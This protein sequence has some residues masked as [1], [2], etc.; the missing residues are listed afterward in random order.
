MATPVVVDRGNSTQ[1][2]VDAGVRPFQAPERG[3]SGPFSAELSEPTK[4]KRIHNPIFIRCQFSRLAPFDSKD[5]KTRLWHSAFGSINK[6]RVVVEAA[7]M[8]PT[9]CP[10]GFVMYHIE[11]A[12]SIAQTRQDLLDQG[13]RGFGRHSDNP[14]LDSFRVLF[15]HQNAGTGYWSFAGSMMLFGARRG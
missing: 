3:E 10:G 15:L 6:R 11:R 14:L 13:R 7:A 5:I 9:V 8:N 1:R 12:V 4:A 2:A